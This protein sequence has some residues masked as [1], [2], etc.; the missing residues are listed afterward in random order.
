MT[1]LD[2][3]LGIKEE[4]R[5]ISEL[6]KDFMETLVSIVLPVYNGEKYLASAIDSIIAQSYKNWELIIV[7]DCSTD[8]SAEIMEQYVKKDERIRVIHNKENLNQPSSLNVGFSQAK[9]V[10][11]TW[12]SDD[13]LLK[14]EMLDTLVDAMKKDSSLALVYSNYTGI[15]EAGM[16]MGLCEVGEPEGLFSG[17]S[18]GA[19][20]LYRAQIAKQIGEYDASLFMSADYDYWIRIFIEAPIKKIPMNLYYY[21]RHGGSLTETKKDCIQQQTFLAVWKN[22]EKLLARAEKK[23]DK[24]R[25][26]DNL[27]TQAG[28][29]EYKRLLAEFKQ[30]REFIRWRTRKQF[31]RKLGRIKRWFLNLGK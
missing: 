25:L 7:N 26:K 8:S 15:D 22:Y 1:L 18:V 10:Y 31:R 14:P 30:D 9:G 24:F 12:T 28:V 4:T 6:E 5:M 16:E 23:E 21:R 20:F 3:R 17:D 27:L 11:Y 13:N 29:E 2:K 19:S